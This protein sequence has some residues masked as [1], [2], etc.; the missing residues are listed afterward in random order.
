MALVENIQREELN[1][2]EIAI[3]Y[4]RLIEECN[5]THEKLADRVGKNRTTVTNFIRLLKLPVEIQDAV[6]E[7]KISMGHARALRAVED[8]FW[9]RKLFTETLNL[10]LSV[11]SL[12]KKIANLKAEKK[13]E[14]QAKGKIPHEYKGI[15]QDFRNFFGTQSV[16]LNLKNDGKGQII[17]KFDSVDELNQLLDRIDE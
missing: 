14:K 8:L 2:I 6:K 5:L 16:E 11:R 1:A 12:E 13:P 10:N 7:K 17:I 3:T 9:Q 4:Q 15:R